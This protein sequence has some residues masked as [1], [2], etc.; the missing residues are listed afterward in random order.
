MN[1]LIQTLLPCLPGLLTGIAVAAWPQPR[2]DINPALLYWQAFNALPEF[3]SGDGQYLGSDWAKGT[4]GPGAAEVAQRYDGISKLLRRAAE[5]KEPCDWGSDLTD[6]P[7]ATQPSLIKLR[8][9]AQAIALRAR[10][11]LEDGREVD[12]KNDLIALLY[13]GRRTAI[14]GL[15]VQ[16]MIGVSIEEMVL[17]FV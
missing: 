2:T 12:S 13:L 7:A 3:R 5:M 1:K 17:S 16:V 6:G 14:D 10:V 15:L 9:I 8:R 11:A 4:L